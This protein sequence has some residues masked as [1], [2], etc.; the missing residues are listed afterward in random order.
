[1]RSLR[2]SNKDKER[3]T[4]LVVDVVKIN[5]IGTFVSFE[6]AIIRSKGEMCNQM[7]GDHE[8]FI[9]YKSPVP[10]ASRIFNAWNKAP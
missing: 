8:I 7:S 2:D 3:K 4:M 1:M 10:S 5:V 9:V 6:D